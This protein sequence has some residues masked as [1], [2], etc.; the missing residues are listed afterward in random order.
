MKSYPFILCLLSF[1][2]SFA[3][4]DSMIVE[5]TDGSFRAY[6]LS[7][8][9]NVAF[10][11]GST[12]VPDRRLPGTVAKAFRIIQNYP[13]P[14]NPT[15]NIQF[16]IPRSGSVTI[17]IFD[18]RGRAIRSYPSA[19]REAGVHSIVWDGR[20]DAHA[21]VSSGIYFCRVQF[22]NDFLINK[23]TLIK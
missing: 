9:R 3:Q 1:S 16:E 17:A 13:N 15:T 23:L 18:I 5:L 10:S 6:A 12:A 7:S 2:V 19:R 21:A 14:F 8:I 20:D 11:N 4:T 22:E